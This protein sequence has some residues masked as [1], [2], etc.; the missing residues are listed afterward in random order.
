MRKIAAIPVLVGLFVS[1]IG[2]AAEENMKS[3]TPSVK[4]SAF[5]Q[6][7]ATFFGTANGLPTEDVRSV[8]VTQDKQ[9]YAGTEKGLVRLS[10]RTWATVP[11]LADKP[12]SL[13]ASA[14]P[15]NVLAIA[16]RGIYRVGPEG[17]TH[18]ADLPEGTSPQGL[19][20]GQNSAYI[21][22][23]KG[24]FA[25]QGSALQAADGLNAV[26]KDRSVSRALA[27]DRN[28][29]VVIGGD[30]GLYR[31]ANPAAQE[32]SLL[33]VQDVKRSWAL[34]DLRGLVF[35]FA[36]RLWFAS[37]QGVGC[38]APDGSW[39]LYTGGDGLPYNDFTAIAPGEE[40]V[41]WFG[42][43]MGAIR[44][45]GKHWSYRQGRLWLPDDHVRSIAVD[46][47]G[48]AW[49]ATPKGIS[50][51]E[52]RPMTL[53]DKAKFYE[54][55]IDKYHRRT[56]YG[57][58]LEVNLKN[59]GDKTE[60]IQTD[61]DNDG[62]WTSMYGAGECFAY[63]ATKSP[64]AK[65]RAKAAFEALRFLGTVTQ[66]GNP[67]AL[68]GFVAR[69]VL[70]TSGPNPNEKNYTPE[71]D[72][73]AQKGDSLWKVMSPR[74][75]TSADGKWYWKCDTSS[76]E[77]D[78]HYFFYALYYD[79]VAD[80]EEEK[81]RVR[82]VVKAITDHLVDHD[83]CLVDWDG[84]PTRWAVYSPRELNHNPLWTPER[85]LNSLSILSYLSVAEHMTGEAKYRD[86]FDMLVRYESY[87]MNM[88]VPKMQNGVGS[89][90]HSDDEMAFM[91]FYGLIRYS[92]DPV[93]REMAR[94]A[95]RN[96]WLLEQPELNPFFNFTY[97][98]VSLGASFQDPFGTFDLSPKGPWLEQSLE[99]LERFPLDRTDWRHTNSQRIDILPL[100]PHTQESGNA[101]GKGYRRNGLVIPVDETHFNHWNCD[102]WDLV[103]GGNGS[104]LA[105]GAV[106]LLPYYM[107]LYHGFIVEESP[108]P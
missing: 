1:A 39:S 37:P 104:G 108:N 57:Y 32:H 63:A 103:T 91:S 83:F 85:G 42:T 101:R 93:V 41:I 45:D 79:L 54:D 74:W 100:P 84:K 78:G 13:V 99:T 106:Y 6:E 61:S 62:L 35:D 58:V 46:G 105:D 86:A 71:N 67:P 56:E 31:F 50:L 102:P 34:Y 55:E 25:M 22:T 30:A 76:D 70:P 28:G 94:F 97:G 3:P 60:W 81:Q 87:A 11:G 107:G 24:V 10:G 5:R 66:G 9:V 2:M 59:P 23:D 27:L 14:P 36:G 90:N 48:N 16:E 52:R 77:L 82:D 19:A 95:F 18:V 21:T 72:R 98:G 89:G 26:T 33:R 65:K 92:H 12:V 75:P 69:T 49:I 17:A 47:D 40:G 68:P 88:M 73:K 4:V 29:L 38:A 80:T 53:K 44:F 64:E 20:V 8:A 15:A 7:V 51:I 43:A 96:Y